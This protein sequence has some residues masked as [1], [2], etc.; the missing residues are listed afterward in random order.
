MGCGALVAI[1]AILA[2][3]NAIAAWVRVQ[4]VA[5]QHAVSPWQ[6]LLGRA[7]ARTRMLRFLL[8]KARRRWL[9]LSSAGA[10]RGRVA[11]DDD[12]ARTVR[13]HVLLVAA[14]WHAG[15][16]LEPPVCSLQSAPGLHGHLEGRPQQLSSGRATVTEVHVE[17][18]ARVNPVKGGG[19][20]GGE[21]GGGRSGGGGGRPSLVSRLSRHNVPYMDPTT[22]R[23]LTAC[24]TDWR[25]QPEAVDVCKA[26]TAAQVREVAASYH[27]R[28]DA[29]Y[30]PTS[31]SHRPPPHHPP[32]QAQY[33]A[34]VASASVRP[35]PLRRCTP[36]CSNSSSI[37]LT[38][39]SCF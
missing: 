4:R 12:D 11:M 2:M 37:C 24:N 20:S 13:G 32:S 15:L 27:A 14:G 9:K 33:R 5:R 38:S 17:V 16:H 18:Q 22:R 1:L 21:S 6:L 31:Q 28:Y 25:V 30:E 23:L 10:A 29:T 26:P 39:V 34:Y 19:E 7:A 36:T 3:L 8:V 35:C